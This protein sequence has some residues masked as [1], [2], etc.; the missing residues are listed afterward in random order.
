MNIHDV[1]TMN[2][3]A[4]RRKLLLKEMKERMNSGNIGLPVDTTYNLQHWDS[5]LKYLRKKGSIE[6]VR[7]GALKSKTTYYIVKGNK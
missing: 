6:Q 1:Y 4:G 2:C 7:F 5:D 3:G